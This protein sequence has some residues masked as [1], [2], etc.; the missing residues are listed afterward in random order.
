MTDSPQV[1]RGQVLVPG[2][3]QSARVHFDHSIQRII[4]DQDAPKDAYLLPGFIDTH[5]HGG[6]GGDT[7]DGPEGVRLM[8]RF[9][10]PHGTTSFLPTTMTAQWPLVMAA[11]N[12]VRAVMD[13][14]GVTG[15]AEI[16]GAHLEGPFISPERLGAQPPHAQLPTP[17]KLEQVLALDV[18]RAVTLAPELPGALEAARQFARAGVRV[19]VG[20]TAGSFEHTWAVLEAVRL[21][22]GRSAGTHTFNAMSGLQ[23]RSPGPLGA[24]LTHPSP[25]LELIVD[26]FHLHPGSVHLAVNAAPGRAMLITDAIRAA[27]MLEGESELGGQRVTVK[28]GKPTLSNGSLAGSVLTMDRALRHAVQLGIPLEQAARMA[29]TVPACSLGLTDRGEI[30]LGLRADL[31]VLDAELAV[32]QVFIAG[33]PIKTEVYRE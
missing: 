23:G 12:G 27:G 14:G 20:H 26:G 16:L 11:L 21:E 4:P 15:G 13:G 17:E 19:G 2:G 31:V 30:T 28:Q 5:I 29:S 1:F 33:V 9:H 10:A 22:G 32:E 6:N 7:M 8:A 18:V 3:F 25:F 24:L